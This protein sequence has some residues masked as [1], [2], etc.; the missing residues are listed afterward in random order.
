[1]EAKESIFRHLT[2]SQAYLIRWLDYY[3]CRIK[4]SSIMALERNLEVIV[5]NEG[6]VVA[7]RYDSPEDMKG[8]IQDDGVWKY[9]EERNNLSMENRALLCAIGRNYGMN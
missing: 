5:T 2:G 3:D 1:M 8:M 6:V 7:Y 4:I 9:N